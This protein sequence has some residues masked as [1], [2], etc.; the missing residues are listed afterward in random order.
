MNPG[1]AE[2]VLDVD[3]IQ[4]NILAGFRKDQQVL[5]AIQFR[6]LPSARKWL[7]RLWPEIASMSEVLRFNELYRVQR[8]R[9][10][11]DTGGLVST[12]VNVAFSYPAVKALAGEAAADRLPSGTDHPFQLGMPVRGMNLGDPKSETWEVGGAGRVPDA[13]LIVASDC[14]ERLAAAVERIKP[15]ASD[16]P[17]A[18]RIV[19]QEEGRTRPDLPGHEHFGFKDGISQP[20]V[21]GRVSAAPDSFLTPRLLAP[22]GPRTVEFAAP[23]IPLVWPGQFVFDYPSTD[24]KTGGPLAPDQGVP[25]E[26]CTPAWARNGSFLV[27]RRLR[28]DVAAFKAFMQAEAARLAATPHFPGLTPERLGALL[29]GRWASGAPVSRSPLKDDSEMAQDKLSNNDFVFTID[30]PAPVF[31]PGVEGPAQ[32]FPS[33]TEDGFGFVCPRAAHI[34]KVNPRDQD[35]DFGS[36][37]D[38]L[39]RRILRRGI[40]YG[41][42]LRNDSKDDGVDRGL[43][44]LCY[45]TNIKEQFEDLQQDWANS[46]A[47]PVAG[48]HDVVIGQTAEGKRTAPIASADGSHTENIVTPRQWVTMTG[49]G[50]FFSPSISA[51]RDVFAQEPTTA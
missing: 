2:P 37:F 33:A 27:F 14:P 17:G 30:T 11:R 18:P 6:K 3:D 34:R 13:L 21:R 39:T 35:T 15:R 46:T 20:G 51:L 41:P 5:V 43:H 36:Q 32:A 31:R 38:T 26:Q 24:R 16:G 45:V 50:Y 1:L 19:W 28:Q 25:P 42:P 4:G 9:L 40:P 10:G 29:V 7:R 44:F 48:G 12:W 47:N 23:G 22:S 49:G 8:A